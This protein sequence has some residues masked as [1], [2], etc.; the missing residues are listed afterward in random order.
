MKDE[1]RIPSL[2]PEFN[3]LNLQ[4]EDSGRSHIAFRNALSNGDPSPL[5]SLEP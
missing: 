1:I 5:V 3:W 4:R 2:A